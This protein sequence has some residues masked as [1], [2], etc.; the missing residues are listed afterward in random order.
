MDGI[1]W[2]KDS[3]IPAPPQVRGDIFR[4]TVRGNDGV[5]REDGV[6]PVWRGIKTAGMQVVQ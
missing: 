2:W 1:F 3:W 5:A 4:L 6:R